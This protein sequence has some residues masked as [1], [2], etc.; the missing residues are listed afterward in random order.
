[1]KKTDEKKKRDKFKQ[2]LGK[3]NRDNSRKQFKGLWNKENW[4][5]NREILK[6]GGLCNKERNIS[7]S[8]LCKK[9]SRQN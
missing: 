6:G 4:Q 2:G 7:V 5:W 8:Y 3:K 9:N 1:M